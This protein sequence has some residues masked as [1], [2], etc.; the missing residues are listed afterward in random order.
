MRKRAPAVDT[1]GS[2]ILAARRPDVE[3]VFTRPHLYALQERA[4]FAPARYSW[5]EASTKSGKTHGCIAWLFE[6]AYT[7]RRPG[8]NYWWIAPYYGQARIAFGRM[9]RALQGTG[10]FE[11]NTSR[12]TITLTNGSVIWFKSAENPDA[13]YG[14]DVEAAVIDEAS[15]VREASFHAIRSTLTATR[16]PLRIIG[17]VKGRSNWFYKGCRNARGGK[18]GHEYHVITAWDSVAA[19]VLD[20]EEIEDAKALL[21]LFIFEELYECKASDDGWNPFGLAFIDAAIMP[22]LST[23]PPVVWGWDL[24]KKRDWTVGVGLDNLGRMC[25]AHRFQ[26][27]W[28]ETTEIIRRITGKLPALVD[29]T[30]VGDPVLE[31]LQRPQQSDP[32]K[33]AP[34]RADNFEGFIFTG[35][36]KQ[37]LMEGLAVAIQDAQLR[38]TDKLLDDRG[39]VIPVVSELQEFEYQHTRTGVRYNAPEGCNDDCVAALGLAWHA[40]KNR[41]QG[42][43]TVW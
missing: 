27:P 22:V 17:N 23:M 10:I 21:P 35:P 39:H 41:K 36:S 18:D 16:G 37:Q 40:Y 24:A 30:G 12:Q 33:P 14:D 11:V 28:N 6:Q 19:G 7:A 43:P 34:P 2:R 13:L 42:G 25:A 4:I 29:S 8:L 3:H 38:I 31:N 15:R 20:R 1:T 32:R 26:K 5:I 9:Q